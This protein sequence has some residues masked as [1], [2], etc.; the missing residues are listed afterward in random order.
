MMAKMGT[1][2]KRDAVPGL[3]FMI[4]WLLLACSSQNKEAGPIAQQRVAGGI[5]G[6]VQ[7]S[8]KSGDVKNLAFIPVRLVQEEF[9]I[10]SA[11]ESNDIVYDTDLGDEGFKDGLVSSQELDAK[12][13]AKISAFRSFQ[14]RLPQKTAIPAIATVTTDGTGFYKFDGVKP[15]TYWVNVDATVANN[16]V[17]W[18]ARVEVS[19]GQLAKVDL[20]NTNAEYAFHF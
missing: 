11:A 5:N 14:G 6:L 10:L 7:V 15:G 19:P 3:L 9:Q 2:C 4:S 12:T 17:G 18:S 20:N 8:L 16:Y 1:L 13:D